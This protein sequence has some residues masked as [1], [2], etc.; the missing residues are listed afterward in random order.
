[1]IKGIS[2]NNSTLLTSISQ[3]KKDIQKVE[4]S[5]VETIKEAMNNG[6][7]KIDINKTAESLAKNLL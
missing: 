5:K 1:M 3:E 7:Y 2:S 6:T 4:K